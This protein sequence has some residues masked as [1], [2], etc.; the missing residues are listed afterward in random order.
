MVTP[1]SHPR[2]TSLSEQRARTAEL[3]RL[4][5][6]R[7]LTPQEQA[8]ADNLAHRAYLRAWRATQ[9]ERENTYRRTFAPPQAQGRAA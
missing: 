5:L 1:V 4:R 6:Q 8:E 3:D 7:P 9:R 2:Q